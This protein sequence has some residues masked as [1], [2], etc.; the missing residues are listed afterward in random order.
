MKRQ[1]SAFW[2][3]F[4]M[5]VGILTLLVPEEL[6]A[7]SLIQRPALTPIMVGSGLDPFGFSN[8]SNTL[9]ID[10]EGH[11]VL[12]DGD[13]LWV[14]E[15]DNQQWEDGEK[16]TLDDLKN[17]TGALSWSSVDLYLGGG[18][19]TMKNGAKIGV[20]NIDKRSGS[21]PESDSRIKVDIRKSNL[22]RISCGSTTRNIDL[23]IAN[24][25]YSSTSNLSLYVGSSSTVVAVGN[26]YPNSFLSVPISASSI[27]VAN[28]FIQMN[29]FS[30]A[31]GSITLDGLTVDTKKLTLTDGNTKVTTVNGAAVNV[32]SCTGYISNGGS[33]I[34]SQPNV[35]AHSYEWEE[36]TP[37]TCTEVGSQH[38]KC[39][40]CGNTTAP[41]AIPALNHV[42]VEDKAV[43]ATCTASGLIEG[44][45][46][47]R[48]NEVLV[49]QQTV[50]AKGHSLTG[51]VTTEAA[52]CTAG[53]AQERHCTI[54]G[55]NYSEVKGTGADAAN[56]SYGEWVI[57]KASTCVEKGEETRTCIHCQKA[58]ETREIALVAHTREHL[59]GTPATCDTTGL[60]TVD[61]C[62][63]CGTVWNTADVV[64]GTEDSYNR[65]IPALGHDFTA[66][67]ESAEALIH[68]ATCTEPKLLHNSCSRCHLVCTDEEH[69]FTVGDPLGHQYQI[70]HGSLVL[71]DNYADAGKLDI[72]CDRCDSKKEDFEFYRLKEEREMGTGRL[73]CQIFNN[74]EKT[75]VAPTCVEGRG[76]YHVVIRFVEDDREYEVSTRFEGRLAP[77]PDV[78][79][80]SPDDGICHEKH[81][82]MQMD[83]DGNVVRNNLGNIV[84]MKNA[85]G[86][87]IEDDSVYCATSYLRHAIEREF[88]E[89]DEKGEYIRDYWG[90]PI[91]KRDADGNYITYI[92]WSAQAYDSAQK[93]F[94][95]AGAESHQEGILGLFGDVTLTEDV[96]L[97]NYAPLTIELN[98]HKLDGSYMEADM[99]R[100]RQIELCADM[101]IKNGT[102]LASPG[103]WGDGDLVIDNVNVEC[104]NLSWG[105][106]SGGFDRQDVCLQNGSDVTVHGNFFNAGVP[107]I[108]ATSVLR[109]R[110]PES[111]YFIGGRSNV[112]GSV[113]A[114]L[115]YLDMSKY[116]VA[117][118]SGSKETFCLYDIN[119]A[120]C[121]HPLLSL[122]FEGKNRTEHI[123]DYQDGGYKYNAYDAESNSWNE[124]NDY[125]HYR[126]CTLCGYATDGAATKEA[127]APEHHTL[128]AEGSCSFC[129]H[130][131]NGLVYEEK[132][133]EDWQLDLKHTHR[134][135]PK[136]DAV[137]END[138]APAIYDDVFKLAKNTYL[139][140]DKTCE[141]MASGFFYDLD[142]V[143]ESLV[144]VCLPAAIPLAAING[145]LYVVTGFEEGKY[146][147]SP[148]KGV[149]D[150]VKNDCTVPGQP[151]LVMMNQ[152]AT[153]LM[154]Q[155]DTPI[156][157][158][159]DRSALSHRISG[160]MRHVGVLQKDGA[161]LQSGSQSMEIDVIDG[162]W[163]YSEGYGC[164]LDE[165]I[166]TKWCMSFGS[167][168]YLT[169]KYPTPVS[170]KGYAI[171][172]AND[173]AEYHGRNPKSW[174]L[175]GSND[176]ESWTPVHQ[177][178]NDEVLED[179]NYTKYEF[180]L[181]T[182]SAEYTH[183]KWEITENQGAS[184]MQVSEFQLLFDVPELT[185][186]TSEN[187]EG[188]PFMV[189]VSDAEPKSVSRFSAYLVA[190]YDDTKASY[191][192][193]LPVTEVD[194]VDGQTYSRSKQLAGVDITY[195]RNFTSADKW[196]ALY[197]PFAVEAGSDDYSL[198]EIYAVGVLNDTNGD[199]E[200]D[201]TDDPV[202][203]VNKL[204]PG[205]QT[206]PNLPYLIRPRS[207]G[208]MVLTSA[209]GVLAPA[210][211][212]YV[213]CG[214]TREQYTFRG[215]YD[216]H[217]LAP[218]TEYFMSTTG[219]LQYSE[220][221]AN[222]KS[223]RWYMTRNVRTTGGYPAAPAPAEIKVFVIGEDM[224]ME[225]AIEMVR[226]H[227]FTPMGTG[228]TYTLGGQRV[229]DG[230]KLP[231]GV[232]IK[233]GRKH[234]VK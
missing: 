184:H 123:W 208:Q 7:K 214:T 190:P 161:E 195:T 20:V 160:N 124:Y 12:I 179:K 229:N 70:V 41:S 25:T 54:K 168:L 149:A 122:D 15:N 8:I 14:D 43:A 221:G 21:L 39:T 231:A 16:W 82:Q 62:H 4:S 23:V 38:Q 196:F 186:F 104:D 128:D 32:T 170:V 81:Y 95:A 176:G 28:Y 94:E 76:L 114:L 217:V 77:N 194:L 201:A 71:D 91:A 180:N 185:F 166:E 102:L 224:D 10:A 17:E 22:I 148:A 105:Y 42:S 205:E 216:T 130:T 227:G 65:T 97:W 126:G 182:P 93:A 5:L 134:G 72:A 83:E 85:E 131:Q 167:P 37:A 120:Q 11:D 80:W 27:N 118:T 49:A 203:I 3:I 26:V 174:T 192:I 132:W 100:Y 136:C 47:S 112:L 226:E 29:N 84:Y 183:F 125:F 218:R 207:A 101:T 107:Q 156:L 198:A 159:T 64:V 48:C 146:M 13:N 73:V 228:E 113:S 106:G 51:W 40:E 210:E 189:P 133:D 88:Y 18:S 9:Y 61:V 115:H 145:K 127:V 19:L 188:A 215:V 213:V 36:I 202:L 152:G 98:G 108:D 191:P 89:L 212:G 2:Q 117:Y 141:L 50:A 66:E 153:K 142:V 110:W 68:K 79:N 75:I 52:T 56:H 116:K 74:L 162:S 200:L 144:S 129:G 175:Y 58:T 24:S 69:V 206:A 171:T 163:S 60:E 219:G 232:Y 59:D 34:G 99:M 90:Y 230:E 57:T 204:K 193:D 86:N 35:K 55:C 233:D 140:L 225:T 121:E 33:F 173:N 197:V 111:D 222:L 119:D 63:V 209:D 30:Y 172:T 67:V 87:L 44:S 211:D 6:I 155:V 137:V 78:H 154:N 147:C 150:M 139:K 45:H 157:V 178:T 158:S 187:V 164:A 181:S 138:V 135:C 234:L 151:Y 103:C 220:N 1:E 109:I 92:E 46:C 143:G 199:G 165:N 223:N 31:K 96:K 169:F 53:G 177:V